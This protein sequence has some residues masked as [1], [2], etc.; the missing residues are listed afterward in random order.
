M[1]RTQNPAWTLNPEA[2]ERLL[3]SLGSDRER[4]AREYQRIRGKLAD[5]FDCRGCDCP[6]LL[7]DETLDRVARRLA[8]G[9]DVQRLPNYAYGVARRVLL[10]WHKR[11]TREE[12]ALAALQ[13]TG[14]EPR[15]AAKVEA[16]VACLERCLAELPEDG[17][18]LIVAYYREAGL[19]PLEGRKLLAGRLG[20][21]YGTLKTRAHRIRGRLEE[22]LRECL[23]AGNR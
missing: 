17:R 9:E 16:E 23:E 22:C 10:E 8:E 12:A 19:M 13:R 6:D 14:P 2:F 20:L 21:T 1:P 15:D 5:F 18:A 4:A 11:H 7:A 3:L